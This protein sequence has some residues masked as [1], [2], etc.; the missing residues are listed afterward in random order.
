[1]D[2]CVLRSLPTGE[3]LEVLECAA[4]IH[5]VTVKIF[6]LGI[7]PAGMSL[8]AEHFEEAE[9]DSKLSKVPEAFVLCSKK[10]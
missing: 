3:V 9:K 2:D 6:L 5:P 7:S 10:K 4:Q 8:L 1:M